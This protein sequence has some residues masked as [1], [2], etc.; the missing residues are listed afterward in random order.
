M[1]N[2]PAIAVW[3]G[4]SGL[5]A[6]GVLFLRGTNLKERISAVALVSGVSASITGGFTV[7]TTVGLGAAA[8]V[9]LFVSI[10]MGYEG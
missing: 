1:S 4:L 6:V 2:I 10:L 9:L 7:N 3:A 8:V 5:A